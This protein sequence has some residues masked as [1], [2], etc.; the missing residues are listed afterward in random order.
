MGVKNFF[1]LMII[2]INLF[3]SIS[4]SIDMNDENYLNL[5]KPDEYVLIYFHAP[6]SKES[7][8]ML[9]YFNRLG[10]YIY[11]LKKPI[12]TF[13]TTANDEKVSEFYKIKK[14]PTILFQKKEK[15]IFYTGSMNINDVVEWIKRMV[16]RE[17]IYILNKEHLNQ[18]LTKAENVIA[19][20]GD[21][22]DHEYKTY[23]ALIKKKIFK[24]TLF[25]N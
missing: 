21:I 15:V 18:V 9:Y 3:N 6:W 25:C 7:S 11:D 14:Y 2:L 24:F 5:I 23:E 20:I 12:K 22:K 16:E 4:N 17:P 19:Y 13:V 10:Y 8:T 1:K